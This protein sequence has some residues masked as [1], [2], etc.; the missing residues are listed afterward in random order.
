MLMLDNVRESKGK[1]FLSIRDPFHG[2]SLEIQESAEFFNS[3]SKARTMGRWKPFSCRAKWA[4]HQRADI[5]S[6][7]R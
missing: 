2:T 1:F 7:G 4:D 5:P 3:G 6:V